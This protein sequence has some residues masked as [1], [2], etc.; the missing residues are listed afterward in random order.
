LYIVLRSSSDIAG[1]AHKHDSRHAPI[2][3]N[4]RPNQLPGTQRVAVNRDVSR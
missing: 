4:R 3:R 1:G 2:A